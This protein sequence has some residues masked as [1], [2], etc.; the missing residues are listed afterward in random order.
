M[1][2]FVLFGIYLFAITVCFAQSIEKRIILIGDA[3]EIN[4]EQSSLIHKAVALIKKDSTTVFFLGDNI[5]P[6]GMGLTGVAKEEGIKSIQSQF[7]PFRQQDVPVYFLAGNHDWNVSRK[8]GL[9]KLK[10]Q[11]DFLKAQMDNH[12]SLIPTAGQPGPVSIPLAA[13]L[14]VIAYDSEYWLYPF[15]PA[16][17]DLDAKRKVF[18]DSL[19]L[20]F[21]QNKDKTVLVLSHHP[22]ITYGEHSLNFGWKQHIFPFTRMNKKLYI[23]LPV[24]GSLYPLW[25]GVIFKSAE[26]LPSKPYQTLVHSVLE[27]RGD[28]PNVV[29]AAGHDHGLQFITNEDLVQVVSGSG[30][31]S[32]FILDNK[33]LK[34]KYQ[35]QGF[36]VA[37]YLSNGAIRVSYYIFKG[38]DTV[39]AYETTILKK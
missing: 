17:E 33:Q 7:E 26:D 2:S 18:V 35:Q 34:F 11:D 37:D 32:S 25:R 29:F 39:K 15:H 8:G 13:D 21:D 20:L 36:C 30:S 38:A 12:L 24:L 5:Y 22:M 27:A 16:D 3:G 10:A 9:E 6:S 1:K 19:R 28:H 14:T 31:K 23:P 4:V